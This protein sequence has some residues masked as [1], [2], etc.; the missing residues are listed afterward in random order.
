MSQAGVFTFHASHVRLAKD[1]VTCG[2]QT[3][4][5]LPTIDKREVLKQELDL[6]VD[7]VRA[8]WLG[9]VL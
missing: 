1:L 3:G 9:C 8:K 7:T 6:Q 2:A 5:D 4:V